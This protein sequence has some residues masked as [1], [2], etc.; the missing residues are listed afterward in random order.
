MVWLIAASLTISDM[1][2]NVHHVKRN[3][4]AS[5]SAR[6]KCLLLAPKPQIC[7]GHTVED[8]HVI[9]GRCC[10]DCTMEYILRMTP[11]QVTI[12]S[13]TVCKYTA[14]GLLMTQV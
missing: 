4:F 8:L 10:E 13:S 3:S 12:A 1:K 11:N 6:S 5:V 2:S 9:F 7:G 14:V